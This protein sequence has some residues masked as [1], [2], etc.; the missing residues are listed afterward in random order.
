VARLVG[1]APDLWSAEYTLAWQ[2]GLVPIPV[3]MTVIRLR[4]GA[5]VVHSPAPLDAA[6][7]AELDALGRVAFLVVPAAHGKFARVAAAAYPSAQVLEAERAPEAWAGEVE[8]QL[9]AG[10]RLREVVLL[11]R[12]SRTLVIT[13]LAFNIHRA[14]HRFARLFFRANGMWQHFGPSRLIRRLAVSSRAEMR[15]SL[16]AILKWDFERILPGHG[17]VVERGGPAALRAAWPELVSA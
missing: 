1:H 11:H 10:F 9:V 15:R 5:L 2:F 13:D 8:T 6:L 12:P 4:D 17:E 3:R 14:E 16:E 7:R